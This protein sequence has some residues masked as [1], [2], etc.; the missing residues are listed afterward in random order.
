M[1][2]SAIDTNR[3]VSPVPNLVIH[4]RY[5]ASHM[6]YLLP[7]VHSLSWHMQTRTIGIYRTA[8]R[9]HHQTVLKDCCIIHMHELI[10]HMPNP[11]PYLFFAAF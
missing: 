11:S 1:H 7:R 2:D 3:F 10:L 6:Q 5:L 8:I 9:I 4:S